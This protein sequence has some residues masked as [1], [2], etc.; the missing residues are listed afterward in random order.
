MKKRVAGPT[1]S[2]RK[3]N[4]SIHTHTYIYIYRHTLLGLI[5]PALNAVSPGI[6]LVVELI[7]TETSFSGLHKDT[8]LAWLG[9]AVL[10]LCTCIHNCDLDQTE[11]GGLTSAFQAHHLVAMMLMTCTLPELSN[12]GVFQLPGWLQMMCNRMWTT[13]SPTPKQNWVRLS[14]VCPEMS[15]CIRSIPWIQ[16]ILSI[17]GSLSQTLGQQNNLLCSRS[18]WPAASRP[19]RCRSS[20]KGLTVNTHRSFKLGHKPTSPVQ[21]L[22]STE[23][24]SCNTS[25]RKMVN[26]SHFDSCGYATVS[27]CHR[28]ET[29]SILLEYHRD[30]M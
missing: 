7:L 3:K 21:I 11:A 13:L 17:I 10:G 19:S 24:V 25:A 29:G 8:S 18:P 28:N 12:L 9:L 20:P 15:K 6:S 4:P 16:R 1:A 26:E 5:H 30:K 22:P 27:E 2:K 23:A 14:S